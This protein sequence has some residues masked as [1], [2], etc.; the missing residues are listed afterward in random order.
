MLILALVVG[1]TASGVASTLRVPDQRVIVKYSSPSRTEGPLVILRNSEIASKS[2]RGAGTRSD[3]YI[4][5]A[6]EITSTGTCVYI[7]NTTA[8]FVLQGGE[9]SIEESGFLQYPVIILKGVH[10]G[11]IQNCHT[12]G[13]EFG[14]QLQNTEDCSI[15]NCITKDAH[16]G[17]FL[18]GAN[19]CTARDSVEFHND[20]GISLGEATNSLIR[21]NT[22]Y[23]NSQTGIDIDFYCQNNIIYQN[24]IGWNAYYNAFDDGQHTNFTNGQN[25]GNAWSDYGGS[26]NYTITGNDESIDFHATL[27]EDKVLPVISHPDDRIIDVESTEEYL[28][29]ECTDEFPDTYTIFINDEMVTQGLWEGKEISFRINQLPIGVQQIRLSATDAAGN[30]SYDVVVVTVMS[31]ML[32]GIGTQLV[33]IASGVTVAVFLVII[34]IIKKFL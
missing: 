12:N 32:G 10:H 17:I 3:P 27:L 21:N 31:Y 1:M 18:D 9:Y 6:R 33:M 14:I 5:D 28:K 8:F 2:F 30:S 16:K 22:I 11:T 25:L 29:W 34:I 13:G 26:G 23:A 24:R 7:E 15:I 4:L 19:N 20:I